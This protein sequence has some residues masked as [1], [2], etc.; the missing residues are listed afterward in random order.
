MLRHHQ[1]LLRGIPYKSTRHAAGTGWNHSDGRKDLG[2]DYGSDHG[3]HH[4]PDPV[5]VR[6][7]A[8]L[9]S[10]RQYHICCD[11]CPDVAADLHPVGRS[12]V[13]LLHCDV[14]PVQHRLYDFFRA[15]Q[16]SAA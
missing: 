5:Q 16:R 10:D 1:F 11:L 2:C 15:V 13:C 3:K 7:E 12:D 6:P 8:V 4:G 9:Y 14:L